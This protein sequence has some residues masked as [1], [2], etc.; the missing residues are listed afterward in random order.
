MEIKPTVYLFR[1]TLWLFNS[2]YNS[3][4]SLTRLTWT[5][6]PFCQFLFDCF[7]Q[8]YVQLVDSYNKLPRLFLEPKSWFYISGTLVCSSYNLLL[9]PYEVLLLSM[10]MIVFFCW[11]EKCCVAPSSESEHV[12]FYTRINLLSS[13]RVGLVWLRFLCFYKKKKKDSSHKHISQLQP[14][15]SCRWLNT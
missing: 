3:V 8:K 5:F 12:S 9:R 1:F 13:Q 2:Q 6:A 14:R 7:V 4:V 11:W 10:Q 15:G